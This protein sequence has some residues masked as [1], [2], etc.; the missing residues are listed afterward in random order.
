[1]IPM[2]PINLQKGE[3]EMKSKWVA[4]VTSLCLGMVL[5]LPGAAATAE[6]KKY[7]IGSGAMGGA[8]RVG[9]GACAQLLNEQFKD[10]YFFTT[11]ASGGSVENLRRI[12]AGEYHTCWAFIN[13]MDEAWKGVGVFEGQKPFKD[14]RVLEKVTDQACSVAVLAKS[15]IKSFSDFSGKK[16]NLGPA[17]TGLVFIFRTMFKA[18]DLTDKVRVSY[19]N[20]DG[21][22]Q[23][24]KDGQLDVVVSPGGPYVSPAVVEISRSVPIR[25]VEPTIEEE[26]KIE[27]LLP[28]L[29]VSPI[30]ANKA[31]GENA[32]KP[33]KA[34]FYSTYWIALASM[35][36]D[37]IYDIL[38]ATQDPK[39]KELLNKVIN[40]W[41]DAGPDFSVVAKI[42]VPLHSGAVKF[43]K[44]KG[45][46][47]P[48]E[49][50]K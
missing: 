50:I 3:G 23:A 9:L 45:V 47:L 29:K 40:L 25:I 13:N 16:V 38:N 48:P 11:A 28:Y 24:L 7:V 36:D 41:E 12:M 15:P 32:D 26:K 6:V 31:P 30:P 19:L 18:L 43:W 14:M 49:I 10:K 4:I 39:N 37:V 17:G 27:P 21:A 44:E 46:K 33:R 5:T 1:M 42:G 22:A 8:W 20:H 35:P 34:Y 2:Q